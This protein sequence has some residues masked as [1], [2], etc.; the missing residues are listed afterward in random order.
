MILKD[1][2]FANWPTEVECIIVCG[3][4]FYATELAGII[5]MF[6]LDPGVGGWIEHVDIRHA[7]RDE[8]VDDTGGRYI[9]EGLGYVGC[10]DP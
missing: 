2:K 3:E 6:H 8:A 9:R 1:F 4:A 5:V 7:D 10:V